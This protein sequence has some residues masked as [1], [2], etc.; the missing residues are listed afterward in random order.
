MYSR[1]RFVKDIN[2]VKFLYAATHQREYCAAPPHQVYIEPTNACNLRCTHCVQYRS[3]RRKVFMD[4]DLYKKIIDNLTPHQPYIDLYLQGESL[5]HPKIVDMVKYANDKHLSVRIITNTTRLNEEIA[6][7][8]IKAGLD[9]IVFSF[10]A[11][12]RK[13]Y[14]S[15]YRGGNYELVLEN[16][17]NF[18]KKTYLLNKKE[19]NTKIVCVEEKKTKDDIGLFKKRFLP[20]P[21][22]SVYISPL[23]NFQGANDE[24][25]LKPFKDIPRKEWAVCRSPWRNLGV[26]SD[27]FVVA[28]IFDYDRRFIIGNVNDEEP[29]KL[30]N[31]ERMRLFRKAL[32][33]RDYERIEE[34]GQLCSNCSQIWDISDCESRVQ[35]PEHFWSEFRRFLGER[36]KSLLGANDIKTI[37]AK[38]KKYEFLMRH[39]DSWLKEMFG[40]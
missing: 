32:L 10:S 20:L 13:T 1:H 27:G 5:L 21:F 2:Y 8:L 40:Y 30:W 36:T 12:G 25:D 14:E 22:D 6:E 35:W 17:V 39:S 34:N 19:L 9:K 18:L 29:I 31:G 3:K 4:F 33:E 26:Q 38:D 28:C 15:I 23:M 37:E 16:I 7:G 24:I 11:A